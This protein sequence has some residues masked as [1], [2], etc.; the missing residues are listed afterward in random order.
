MQINRRSFLKSGAAVLATG[1]VTGCATAART[2]PAALRG[3]AD[4]LLRNAV[5]SGDVAGAVAAAAPAPG[6]V[7]EKP[8]P[9]RGPGRAPPRKPATRSATHLHPPTPGTAGGTN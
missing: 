5:A 1:A 2:D 9:P 7:S 8:P 6:A 4:A 3:N